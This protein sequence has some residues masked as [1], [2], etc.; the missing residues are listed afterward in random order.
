MGYGPGIHGLRP[1]RGCRTSSLATKSWWFCLQQSTNCV[2]CS[3]PECIRM[4]GR[5]PNHSGAPS[6]T[7]PPTSP[8]SRGPVFGD[9]AGK[10]AT[11][12]VG[13]GRAGSDHGVAAVRSLAVKVD[14]FT[15]VQT[16]GT[17]GPLLQ[18]PCGFSA[19][20]EACTVRCGGPVL[21]RSCVFAD[22]CPVPLRRPSV[23][24][25]RMARHAHAPGP[26]PIDGRERRQVAP[27]GGHGRNASGS[28]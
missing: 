22:A 19:H 12:M 10:A 4:V 15:G 28:P 27:A 17:A 2:R 16:V 7:C 8:L 25:S 11:S 9:A 23:A 24:R 21:H 3:P 6:G 1:W 14:G 5:T 18:S 26:T 13:P 20:D